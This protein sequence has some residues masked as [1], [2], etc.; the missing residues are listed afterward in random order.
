MLAEQTNYLYIH[1]INDYIAKV[2][3]QEE[4][5]CMEDK[6]EKYLPHPAEMHI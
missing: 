6:M 3:F 5:T 4:G 2:K 1:R